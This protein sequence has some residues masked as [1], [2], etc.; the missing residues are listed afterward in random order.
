LC[1]DVI[2]APAVCPSCQ[3]PE[4]R[5]SGVGTEKIESAA[6]AAFKNARI[7]RMDSDTMKNA[8]SYEKMLNSFKRGD[9]DILI[10]TQMIAKGLHFPNVTLVGI[11]MADLGLSSP[12]FRASERTFQ[13]ITQVAGRAGRGE[14]R[15]EVYLQTRKPDNE[16]IIHS[17]NLD[18]AAFNGFNH[19]PCQFNGFHFSGSELL[20]LSF[21]DYSFAVFNYK[22]FIA[23]NVTYSEIKGCILKG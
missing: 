12:D 16:T 4:I 2:P 5:F 21:N 14:L 23:E 15:G 17:M 8:E 19:I 22:L 1:G 11:L 18:F 9:I 3:S 6:I 10:G 13:L 7:G 20:L